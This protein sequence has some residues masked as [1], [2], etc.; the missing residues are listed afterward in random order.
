[1]PSAIAIVDTGPL[2]A[3]AD[4]G[5]PDHG[6]SVA[7]FSRGDLSFVIPAPVATEAAQLIGSRLGPAAEASFHRALSAQDIELPEPSDLERIAELVEH[8]SDFPLGGVDASV[9]ALAERLGAPT[10]ITLDRRHFAAVRP[11]H[12]QSL[13]LLPE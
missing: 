10:V 8:Y 9:I 2:L 7:Q 13:Q 11:R 6:A 5:D 1:M 12:C 3:A 4:E